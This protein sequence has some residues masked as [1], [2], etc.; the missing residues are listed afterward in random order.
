M[1]THKFLTNNEGGYYYRYYPKISKHREMPHNPLTRQLNFF[2]PAD[3]KTNNNIF[4]ELTGKFLK[5]TNA[6]EFI[7][8]LECSGEIIFN[9]HYTKEREERQLKSILLIHVPKI[10][11]DYPFIKDIIYSITYNEVTE[12]E[13]L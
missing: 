5:K 1:A 10:V 2:P 13:F 11:Y 4:H 9:D 6:K 12:Y 8:E 7:V 3:I